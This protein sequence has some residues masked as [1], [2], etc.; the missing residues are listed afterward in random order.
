MTLAMKSPS[1]RSKLGSTSAWTEPL[2]KS[3]QTA[4]NSVPSSPFL[5]GSSIPL[6]TRNWLQVHSVWTCWTPSFTTL[7]IRLPRTSSTT[8]FTNLYKLETSFIHRPEESTVILIL[9]VPYV[10]TENLLL[11]YRFISL[12]IYFNFSSNV[13][14]VPDVGKQDLIVIGNTEAFQTLS[15]SDLAN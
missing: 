11:L 7:R 6:S 4:T 1:S 5:S 2:P 12:P 3:F 14:V 8:S 15:S 9:H 13:S 10:E